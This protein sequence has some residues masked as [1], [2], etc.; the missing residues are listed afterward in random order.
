M[1]RTLP[2]LAILIAL[3]TCSSSPKEK[4][5]RLVTD[6]LKEGLHNPNSYEIIDWGELDTFRLQNDHFFAQILPDYEEHN[7]IM[8]DIFTFFQQ[9]DLSHEQMNR[10]DLPKDSITFFQLQ[11]EKDSILLKQHYNVL[12]N[13][14]DSLLHN[15]I[16]WKLFHSYRIP[17]AR[18]EIILYKDTFYMD[19]E[20]TKVIYKGSF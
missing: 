20:L 15:F 12:H 19:E 10:T 5:K 11:I 8:A 1:K 2:I 9:L 3:V 4:A 16:G 17:N 7:D 14:T 6:C 18:N 13:F